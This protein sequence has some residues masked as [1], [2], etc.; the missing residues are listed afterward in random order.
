[1]MPSVVFL[2]PFFIILFWHLLV[3]RELSMTTPQIF[4]S[5]M[6]T[7]SPVFSTVEVWFGLFFPRCVTFMCSEA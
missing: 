1:M 4:F 7:V 6:L 3:T 2:V 5:D